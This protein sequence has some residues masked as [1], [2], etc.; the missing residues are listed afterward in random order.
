LGELQS[1]VGTLVLSNETDALIWVYNS[2]G[3]YSSQSFYSIINFRG[4]TPVYVRAVWK[5]CVPPKIHLFLWVLS[6]NRL[7]TVDNLNRKGMTKPVQCVFCEENESINHLFFECVVAREVWKYVS[8]YLGYKIGG[9]YLSTKWLSKKKFYCAN[10][11]STAVL[12]GLWLIRNN[13]VFNAHVWLDVKLVLR[14][15][16]RLTMEW[17]VICVADKMEELE[18]WVSSWRSKS[19]PP[20]RSQMDE[21]G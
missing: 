14:R 19:A 15:I 6:H 2:S 21:D 20:C 13:M 4:V 11:I 3:I 9:D 12:R 16:W 5:I 8:E 1:I 7:A 18:R 10:I 17:K